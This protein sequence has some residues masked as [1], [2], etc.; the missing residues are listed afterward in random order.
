MSIMILIRAWEY[1][2]SEIA[3]GW[4]LGPARKRFIPVP[5]P[6]QCAQ[7]IPSGQ[8]SSTGILQAKFL[9]LKFGSLLLF[10]FRYPEMLPC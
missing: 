5:L 7:K 1:V 4:G 8:D 2:M 10:S 3:E 9:H 6:I